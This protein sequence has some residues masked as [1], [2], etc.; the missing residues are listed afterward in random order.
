MPRPGPSLVERDATPESRALAHPNDS[1][2]ASGGR[3]E[4]VQVLGRMI[5]ASVRGLSEQLIPLTE[6]LLA[7]Q[8]DG[9]IRARMGSLGKH[10]QVGA[11]LWRI[12]RPKKSRINRPVTAIAGSGSSH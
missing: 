6:V 3:A 9:E 11:R 8:R 5:D 2:P 4:S 7:Q 1:K 12:R 10:P